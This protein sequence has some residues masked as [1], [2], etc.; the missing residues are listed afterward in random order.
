MDKVIKEIKKERRQQDLKWGTI[1]ERVDD[2]FLPVL[3]EEVGEVARAVNEFKYY[4][5]KDS[6]RSELVQVAAVCVAWIELL[7]LS[8]S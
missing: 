3:M 4:G 8:K 1:Q 2:E 7:D 5:P 6:V